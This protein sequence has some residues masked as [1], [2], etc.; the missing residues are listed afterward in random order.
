MLSPRVVAIGIAAVVTAIMTLTVQIQVSEA[1]IWT[2]FDETYRGTAEVARVD[3]RLASVP[4]ATSP[5]VPVAPMKIRN[6]ED[7]RVLMSTDDSNFGSLAFL[8][9]VLASLAV[10]AAGA[11]IVLVVSRTM[12]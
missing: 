10:V 11:T 8:A 3:A 1:L 5:T 2:G 9:L 4:A 12:R 6:N 7:F